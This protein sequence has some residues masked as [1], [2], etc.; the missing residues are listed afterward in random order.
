MKLS[1]EDIKKMMEVVK[2][3][4]EYELTC[5]HCYD[6]LDLFI[7]MELSGKNAVEVMPLVK[8]HLDRCGACREEYETLLEALKA[9]I[10]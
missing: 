7:E 8:D 2:K 4:R 1:S 6:E 3:T 9:I 10:D 5:G